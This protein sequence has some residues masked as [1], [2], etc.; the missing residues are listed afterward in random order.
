MAHRIQEK[1]VARSAL[2]VLHRGTAMV[3]DYRALKDTQTRRHV[4][5]RFDPTLGPEDDFFNPRTGE[6]QRGHHGGFVKMVDEPVEIP[7]DDPHYAEYVRHLR[8]G[9]LWAADPETAAAAGIAF[10]PDFGGE[11]PETSVKFAKPKGATP[12]DGTRVPSVST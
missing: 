9:D 6:T 3:M 8:D 2:R 11:H 1:Q 7:S 5:L 12:K 4:G 10:E